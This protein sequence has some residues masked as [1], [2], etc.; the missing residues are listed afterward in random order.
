VLQALLLVTIK[1]LSRRQSLLLSL[2]PTHR[3]NAAACQTKHI[4][5]LA[6]PESP[7][8]AALLLLRQL[9]HAPLEC[10]CHILLTIIAAHH[11]TH[12]LQTYS[13]QHKCLRKACV[14]SQ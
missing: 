4:A 8:A 9:C 13:A 10:C 5:K 3:T 14:S 1:I 2:L 7:A 6:A 12:I 11:I